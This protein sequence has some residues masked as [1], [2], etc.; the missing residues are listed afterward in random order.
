[1]ASAYGA[2]YRRLLLLRPAAT[3]A[4]SPSR[5]SLSSKRSSLLPPSC[6]TNINIRRSY[7]SSRP[8]AATKKKKRAAAALALSVH[9][10]H[11]DLGM[12]THEILSR[13][14]AFLISVDPPPDED[15]DWIFPK[16]LDGGGDSANG[17][18]NSSTSNEISKLLTKS[19]TNRNLRTLRQHYARTPAL[20]PPNRHPT[21]LSW[22]EFVPVEHRPA[23]HVLCS[24][25]V[26][27]PW[28]WPGYYDQDWLRGVGVEHCTFTLDV[29]DMNVDGVGGSGSSASGKSSSSIKSLAKFP[30]TPYPI[31]HPTPGTDVA[32]MHLKSEEDALRS[33]NALGVEP[34]HL[35]TGSSDGGS[36]GDYGSFERD[37]VMTF[38]GFEVA[39]DVMVGREDVG[40]NG[41]TN[42]SSSSNKKNS[43]ED[44]RVFLPFTETG[45]LIYASP[46]RFL[47]KTDRPLPEGLCG[48]PTL[49]SDG[50]VAGIVEGIV[51][52][53][54]EDDRL[55]GA[56][57]FLPSPLL[58]EFVDWS[59][60]IML[61]KIVPR[62]LFDKIVALK[63]G[64]GGDEGVLN[65]DVEDMT[66]PSSLPGEND[67]GR[68]DDEE[69]D[70]GAK[71]GHVLTDQAES[72]QKS[73]DDM[74][75]GLHRTHTPEQV[76]AIRATVEREQQEV[77]DIFT[78]EG[79]DLN[80]VIARVR[81][82]T[83]ALQM[84]ILKEAETAIIDDAEVVGVSEGKKKGG[85]GDAGGGDDDSD[86]KIL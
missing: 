60:R 68:D 81:G 2:S 32:I 52:L 13:S 77:I 33:L 35:R 21:Q 39:E 50:Y 3:A 55:A 4:A 6:R 53:D 40:S 63:T 27:A 58:R 19:Q 47:A 64:E 42:S 38:E 74:I 9:F 45:T 8:A 80:D 73:Y 1:M 18:S 65:A 12:K 23:V 51:P 85:G 34:L 11:P 54:H 20:G 71:T 76:E 28:L 83:R 15:D 17:D 43:D 72:L 78:T 22:L 86:G 5:R 31:H 56:A 49:D 79:G 59:E 46:Q 14:T 25:H 41:T 66:S 75:A 29:F 57:A 62:K 30:L 44:T 69:E 82:R 84:E 37:E 10:K 24:S 7:S 16:T 61:E 70:G 48:G 67:T 36:Y 26:V